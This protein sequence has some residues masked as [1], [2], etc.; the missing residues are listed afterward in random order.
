MN[1]N[2]SQVTYSQLGHRAEG[3]SKKTTQ[4]F[5]RLEITEDEMMIK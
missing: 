2:I 3:E 1:I 4:I 5:A